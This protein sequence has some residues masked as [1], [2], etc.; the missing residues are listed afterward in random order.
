MQDKTS[1]PEFLTV[2]ELADLLRIK[3]RKVYE[4]AASGQIP[5]SRVTGKLLFPERDIRAWIAGGSSG[6][7][8]PADDRPPEIFLGSHDP[9]LDWAIRQSRCGLATRFDGSLDGLARFA[10]GEGVAGGLHIHDAE[11]GGWNLPQVTAACSGQNAVLIAWA[12]RN[13]GLVIRP[14]D[15]G[16]IRSMADLAGRTVV[17]RQPESGTQTAFEKLLAAD[18]LCQGDLSLVESAPTEDDA[19]M[20]VAQGKAEVAFGLESVARI[21]GLHFVPI[22]EERFDLLV[23][24]R[25]WF[26]PPLQRLLSF[27]RSESFRTHAKETP[28]YD[29][30]ELGTVRWNA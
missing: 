1:P 12:R 26:E 14:T 2:R 15:V 25:A 20:A 5:V 9:L 3:E 4:L 7:P 21:F 30:G 23:D 10:A 27:C 22:I 24:R 29:M 16:A 18:G 13:R 28:G 8:A 19:V 11:T 6:G 17:P